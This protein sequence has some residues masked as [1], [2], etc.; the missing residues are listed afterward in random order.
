MLVPQL[1]RDK[2]TSAVPTLYVLVPLLITWRLNLIAG[3]ML[4]VQ[5]VRR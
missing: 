4:L 5:L 2:H 3:P 1:K